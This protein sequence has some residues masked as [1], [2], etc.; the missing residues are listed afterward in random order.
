MLYFKFWVVLNNE[1]LNLLFFGNIKVIVY[2]SVI[3]VW[4]IILWNR[5][6]CVFVSVLNNIENNK[7]RLIV[8]MLLGLINGILLVF[9][10]ILL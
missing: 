1:V 10:I 3:I 2:G 8:L 5:F 6:L 7:V 4:L 9:R